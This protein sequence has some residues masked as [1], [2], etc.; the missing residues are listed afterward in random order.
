MILGES[1]YGESQEETEDFTRLW[2]Q[3]YSNANRANRFFT[4]VTKLLLGISTG[5][6]LSPNRRR[7]V[8]NHVAFYNYVQRFPSTTARVRPSPQLWKEAEAP[9][10]QVLRELAPDVVLILGRE[11]EKHAVCQIPSSIVVCAIPHPSSF[12]FRRNEWSLHIQHKLQDARSYASSKLRAIT[13]LEN[14]DQLN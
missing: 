4:V 12:G 10:E 6:N 9:F 5:S 7:E 14:A 2:I 11:L 13:A 8:W 3:S 1:H